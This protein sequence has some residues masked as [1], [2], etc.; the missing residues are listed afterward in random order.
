MLSYTIRRLLLVIPTVFFALV[1]P[2][3]ALLRPPGRPG[4]PD[5]RR[6]RPHPRPDRRSS[7]SRSATASTTPLSSSSR[8]TGSARSSGTSASPSPTA[9]A[10]TT[11]S[12]RRPSTASA[13]RSGPSSSRS[14]S[15]SPSG[16]CPPS[17]ATRS[18]TSSPRSGTAALSAV[19]VFVLGFI[20]QYAFAVYPNKQDWPDWTQLR[21]SGPRPGHVGL[22]RHPDRRAVALPDPARG[23]PGLRVHRPGRPHDAGLDARGPAGRL[24]AD[25]PGQGPG[26]APGHL[27]PRPPQRHAPGHHPDRHR[28]RHGHRR[29]RPHRDRLLLAG[30]RLGDRQLH[31]R[32]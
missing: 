17:G 12:A 21:T 11:S 25:R 10:S 2:L 18:P 23:H 9:A 27:R 13:W 28:L 19:P 20:L 6:W 26:R 24:H 22:L 14:S 15:A 32:P 5:R 30:P 29:R 3:P 7:R 8:T 4:Q 16:C 31:H 1:L